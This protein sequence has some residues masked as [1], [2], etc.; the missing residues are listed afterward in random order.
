MHRRVNILQYL[1]TPSGRWQW[2]PIPKNPGTGNY[3]WS[4][5]QTNNFY[6]VWREQNRRRYQKAG[7]TP[8]QALE[9][10]SKKEF[11]LAGRAVLGQ[12]KPVPKPAENGFTVEAAVADYLEFIK[13]KKRPRTYMRYRIVMVYALFDGFL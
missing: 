7:R 2:A 1:K 3:V 9:A 10:K 6:I 4:K 8:S 11:E 5:A 12:G 13:N